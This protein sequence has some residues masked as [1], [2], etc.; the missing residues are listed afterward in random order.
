MAARLAMST[1]TDAFF[2]DLVKSFPF[3]PSHSQLF[4]D[5]FQSV[6][7]FPQEMLFVFIGDYF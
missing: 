3:N 6:Q 2:V 7:A 5:I 1:P 4:N